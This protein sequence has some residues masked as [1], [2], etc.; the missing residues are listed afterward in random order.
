[1][2]GAAEPAGERGGG[3]AGPGL[4]DLLAED[5]VEDGGLAGRRGTEEADAVVRPGEPAAGAVEPGEELAAVVAVE[6]GREV[7]GGEVG[8]RLAAGVGQRDQLGRVRGR[9]EWAVGGGERSVGHLFARFNSVA[10]L[11]ICDPTALTSRWVGS[12]T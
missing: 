7:P 2:G 3:V 6:N 10:Q 5:E 4:G 8:E 11:V 9:Q 1:A 12:F